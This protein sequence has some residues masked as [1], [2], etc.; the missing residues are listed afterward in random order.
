MVALWPMKTPG[1]LCF[2]MYAITGVLTLQ[3]PGLLTKIGK[4]S[5][6]FLIQ[7]YLLIYWI[8]VLQAKLPG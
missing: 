7:E 8:Q 2:N 3:V 6:Y 5:L 4:G 1:F